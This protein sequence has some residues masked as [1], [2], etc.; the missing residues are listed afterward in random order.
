MHLFLA[1]AIKASVAKQ[2]QQLGA[3]L[4]LLG[5]LVLV[6]GSARMV[7]AGRGRTP[8]NHSAR[9]QEKAALF[10]GFALI[11]LATMAQLVAGVANALK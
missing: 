5:S 2:L 8:P 10:V 6:W 7:M 1:L 4:G 11:S 3:A 9:V